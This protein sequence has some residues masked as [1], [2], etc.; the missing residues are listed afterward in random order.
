ML[1]GTF[2]FASCKCVGRVSCQQHHD[3][4]S[5][6]VLAVFSKKVTFLVQNPSLSTAVEREVVFDKKSTFWDIFRMTPKVTSGTP[7]L[8]G[9]VGGSVGVH[10]KGHHRTPHPRGV[11]MGSWGVMV[12]VRLKDPSGTS[13]NLDQGGGS[14]GVDPPPRSRSMGVIDRVPHR[15]P[16]LGGRV[17]GRGGSWWGHGGSTPGDPPGTPS[18]PPPGWGSGGVGLEDPRGPPKV[19]PRMGGPRG[20]FWGVLGGPPKV[21]PRDPPK[22]GGFGGSLQKT[23]KNLKKWGRRLSATFG[24]KKVAEGAF[25]LLKV[26]QKK[27]LIRRSDPQNPTFG[28]PRDPPKPT[29][30]GGPGG[31]GFGV[32]PGPRFWTPGGGGPGGVGLGGPRGTPK[33]TPR[34]GTLGDPRGGGRGGVTLGV[35]IGVCPGWSFGPSRRGY[36]ETDPADPC[37]RSW[38][39]PSIAS[40]DDG[41]RM[42]VFSFIYL[43]FYVYCFFCFLLCWSSSAEYTSG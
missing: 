27:P 21:T 39:R 1:Q 3:P 43:I 2:A 41:A 16:N 32:P 36:A 11:M 4:P 42:D 35:R 22:S 40:V 17:G 38:T 13:I 31:V 26:A 7:Q 24:S 28:G 12:G 15:P 6:R 20:S 10:P 18:G 9:R 14:V 19:T 33:P 5:K 30:G 29:P 37:L 25:H 8:G 34:E 23:P